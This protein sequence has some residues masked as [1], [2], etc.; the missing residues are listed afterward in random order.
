MPGIAGVLAARN[1]PS[2]PKLLDTMLESMMHEPDSVRTRWNDARQGWSVGGIANSSAD[3]LQLPI[4]NEDGTVKLWLVGECFVDEATKTTLKSHGHTFDDDGADWVVHLYEEEGPEFIKNL[5]GLFSGIVLDARHGRAILFTDRFSLRRLYYYEDANGFYFAS[6]AKAL[7]SA[8]PHL[9][10]IDT[11]SLAEYLCY[12]CVLGERSLFRGVQVLPGGALWI[13]SGGHLAKSCWYDARDC[14]EQAPLDAGEFCERL[15]SALE[16]AVRRRTGGARIG[17]A[18]SGGLDTRMIVSCL[19][20]ERESMTA[21]TAGGMYRDSMDLRIA[22]RLSEQCHLEHETIRVDHE[23]LANYAAIAARAVYVTD[24]LTDATNAHI[25]YLD[26]KVRRNIAPVAI[27]GAFGSQVLGRVR[28]GLRYRAPASGLIHGDFQPDVSASATALS[29]LAPEKGL[30]FVARREIPWYWSRCMSAHFSQYNLRLPFLDNEFFDLLFRAPRE[31]YDGSDF[32]VAAISGRN[33]ELMRV[34][35]NQG[36]GGSAPAPISCLVRRFMLLQGRVEKV[37]NW[38]TLPHSLQ[39]LAA[40][41]DA[42]LLSPLRLDRLILGREYYLH[43]NRWFRNELAETVREI[44][45]DAKTLARPYWNADCV[46]QIVNDHVRGRRNNLAQIRKI[47]TIELIHRELLENSA[48]HGS[49]AAGA[50]A[51][52]ML[53][54]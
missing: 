51:R 24:G 32:E 20:A 43:Y 26:G 47:L 19:P 48:S 7:L 3:S 29:A 33:P 41:V 53:V 42:Q 6:E 34:R 22:R 10:A 45:L 39:H 18:L 50:D 44:L 40:Q 4:T 27:S 37:F 9:R 13:S 14:E 11:Q 52:P 30:A 17:L 12:D 49:N 21:F 16:Q 31:G 5:N 8:F 46:S 54:S 35:T 28:P 23:F 36:R 2:A 15:S 38:D 1:V 25:F